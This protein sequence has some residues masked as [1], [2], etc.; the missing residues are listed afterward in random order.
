MTAVDIVIPIWNS[1]RW[2]GGCLEAL[3]AQT[4]EPRS[5]T[6]VDDASTDDAVD[7][8]SR[9]APDVRTIRLDTHRGFA[10][11]ANRGI[12][13]GSAPLVAL[14]NADTRAD[15][16]WLEELVKGLDS[17]P[18]TVGFAASK[19]LQLENP[20][21][22]DCAGDRFTRYGSALKRGRGEEAGA[23]SEPGPVTSASA[24]AALY[25]RSMLD[26]IGAFEESFGSYF[27]DVELGL[28]AQLA[29]Y[30][31]VYVPSA[32]VLHQG[33]GSGLPR[34]NYVRLVTANRVATVLHTFPAALLWRHALCLAWGQWYFLVA[35]RHPGSTLA[36]YW[37]LLRRLPRVLA[38]RRALRQDRATTPDEFD[39]LLG[40]ELGEPGLIELWRRRRR[41]R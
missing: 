17:A 25:R 23:W 27:E 7:W 26:S 24:G 35:S 3:R 32:R 39:R 31:C 34:G 13:E 33:G 36:G 16:H 10:A 5:V 14:L 1:R 9:H 30:G 15:P 29:G 22:I 38:R 2:I 19:M 21:R 11:T 41:R 20:E 12:A 8:L 4:L 37:D 18:E 28:R 40:R 6:V